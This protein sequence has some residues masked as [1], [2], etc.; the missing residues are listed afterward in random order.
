MVA[1]ICA[2]TGHYYWAYLDPIGAILVCMFITIGWCLTGA[3]QADILSGRVAPPQLYQRILAVCVDH[4]PE[5]LQIDSVVAFHFG[6]KY[7][8]E[9]HVVM[10]E[11]A[12]LR[13]VHDIVEPLQLK[14]EHLPFV[15]RAYLHVDF[16]TDHHPLS[17]HKVV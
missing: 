8:V 3:E 11:S 16:E 6:H 5:I 9:V 10:D 14:I 12:S 15:E 7:L 4:N 2:I 13:C 17:E 1:I